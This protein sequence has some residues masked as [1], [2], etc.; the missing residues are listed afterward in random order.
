VKIKVKNFKQFVNEQNANNQS[1]AWSITVLDDEPI[2]GVKC[3]G[4]EF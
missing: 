4:K 1:K 3:N 2:E